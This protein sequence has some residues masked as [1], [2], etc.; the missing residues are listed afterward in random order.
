MQNIPKIWCIPQLF[1]TLQSKTKNK[2]KQEIN[3]KDTNRAIAFELWTKSPMPMVTLTKTFDVT[4]LYKVSR[5]HGL[6]F[7]MLLCWCIGKAA[8][9]IEE[10]YMLPQNGKLYK[11]DRMAINVIVDNIKGGLSFCDVAVND[12]LEQF[13]ANYLHLTETISQTCQDIL[14]DEAVIVGTSAVTGTELDSIVNQYS[15]IYTLLPIPS[16]PD[17]RLTRH[18][19]PGRTAKDN[20]HDIKNYV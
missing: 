4:R 17:G 3:P 20:Q 15:G 16:R 11:Y 12:D 18:P 10:F 7:N 9:G 13:N 2:M 5:R 6:K 19:I 8:S 1:V 14:D